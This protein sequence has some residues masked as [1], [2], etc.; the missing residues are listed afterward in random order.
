MSGN[1]QDSTADHLVF[2]NEIIPFPQSTRRKMI[3][4]KFFF[5]VG[6]EGENKKKRWPKRESIYDTHNLHKTMD[7]GM[8]KRL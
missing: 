8:Y 5:K 2:A 7:N 6:N 1:N 3:R 4:Q